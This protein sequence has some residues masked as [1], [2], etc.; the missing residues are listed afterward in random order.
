MSMSLD[1]YIA[2][3]DDFLGGEV[4]LVDESVG[5]EVTHVGAVI[6]E[7]DAEEAS[8]VGIE[9]IVDQVGQKASQARKLARAVADR[10]PV[11][12]FVQVKHLRPAERAD[13]ATSDRMAYRL[14]PR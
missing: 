6:E 3:P 11:R 12:R 9:V 10:C 4:G 2:D 8:P 1:G 7:K 13:A 5:D 14:V